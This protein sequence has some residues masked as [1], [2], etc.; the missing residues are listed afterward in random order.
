[1]SAYSDEA[2]EACLYGRADVRQQRSAASQIILLHAL[3]GELLTMLKDLE[4]SAECDTEDG[5]RVFCCPVCEGS[6][7][8]KQHSSSCSLQALLTKAED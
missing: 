6:A 2:Y 5:G 4:W 8:N 7:V 1:M 3:K